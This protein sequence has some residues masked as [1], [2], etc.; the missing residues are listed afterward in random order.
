MMR[1]SGI[2]WGPGYPREQVGDVLPQFFR[3][4]RKSRTF[5]QILGANTEKTLVQSFATGIENDKILAVSNRISTSCAK[6][7]SSY[8]CTLLYYRDPPK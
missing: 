7:L 4:R 5:T 3:G 8:F 6:L 1:Y 2:V